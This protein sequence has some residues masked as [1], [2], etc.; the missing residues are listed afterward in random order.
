MSQKVDTDSRQA[1]KINPEKKNMIFLKIPSQD[2]VIDRTFHSTRDF[3]AGE[4]LVI[5]LTHPGKS[6]N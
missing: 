5:N 1:L 6:I 3:M 2:Y 4:R